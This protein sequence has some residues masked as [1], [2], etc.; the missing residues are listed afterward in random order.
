MGTIEATPHRGTF[1]A[2]RGDLHAPDG[3]VRRLWRRP[4]WVTCTLTEVFGRRVP[5]DTPGH[6]TP[7]FAHDEA[8]ALAAGHRPCAACRREAFDRFVAGWRTAHGTPAE[9]FV[10]AGD[11][12]R[13]LHRARVAR[14][15]QVRHTARLDALPDGAF[16]L[17]PGAQERPALVWQGYTYPWSHAG[18]GEPTRDHAGAMAT[19]LTPA[20]ALAVLAA[21]Y[22]PEI[23]LNERIAA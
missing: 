12:D 10:G 5:F 20:P 14:G 2:N 11:I 13:A 16:V 21:G 18:Y 17:L 8:V 19:V 23:T 3:T 6:Y 9:D 1:L 7:L 4:A 15:R 22:R